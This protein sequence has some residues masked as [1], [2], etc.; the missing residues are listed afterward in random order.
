M[1]IT[2]IDPKAALVLIDLQ[3]GIVSLALAH[4]IDGVIK[5]ASTLA[6]ALRERGLPLILVNVTGSA[7]GR[8]ERKGL[9]AQSL[10]AAPSSI[11]SA[12]E[13]LSCCRRDTVELARPRAIVAR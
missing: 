13:R 4:P 12:H 2:A 10:P 11:T 1:T 7:P 9:T 3:K 6:S 5:N 8:T